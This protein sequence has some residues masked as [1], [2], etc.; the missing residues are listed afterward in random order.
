MTEVGSSGGVDESISGVHETPDK[1]PW[2]DR[3]RF[4]AGMIMVGGLAGAIEGT[5]VANYVRPQ[6]V[7]F[8]QGVDGSTSLTFS[9][10][11]DV[12]IDDLPV[13]GEIHIPHAPID[14]NALSIDGFHT[15]IKLKIDPGQPDAI[16]QVVALGADFD[17]SV[18][19]PLHESIFANLMHGAGIGA[20]VGAGLTWG[21]MK[22][23]R[24]LRND[25]ADTE[26][27]IN[28][29]RQ[30]ADDEDLDSANKQEHKMYRN[31]MVRTVLGTWAAYAAIAGFGGTVDKSLDIESSVKEE[32]ST[33]LSTTVTSAVPELEGATINGAG[34]QINAAI[35]GINNL[36]NNADEFWSQ[37]YDNMVPMINKFYANEGKQFINNPNI[38]TFVHV[39][40]IH[41]NLAN[42]KNYLDKIMPD[43]NPDFILDTGDDQTN[44]GTMFYESRCI[45][46]LEEMARRTGIKLGKQVV[47][48]KVDG[49]HDAIESMQN[50]KDR[51]DLN[52]DHSVVQ[53]LRK[54]VGVGRADPNRTTW[55]TVPG[56]DAEQKDGLAE[57]GH[58]LADDACEQK[59]DGNVVIGVAH[60]PLTLAE[61][62]DKGCVDL[63]V[64][65]HTH[66]EEP[67][68]SF[69][70]RDGRRVLVHVGGTT[71]GADT[72]PPLY[73]AAEKDSTIST[74]YYDET[75]EEFVSQAT[76]TLHPDGSVDMIFANL[77]KAPRNLEQEKNIHDFLDAHPED[78]ASNDNASANNKFAII[79]NR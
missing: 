67:T 18:V 5:A 37:G 53:L 57:T 68:F 74:I 79:D 11:A 4:R 13:K 77:R 1:L 66:D 70:A 29:L 22:Y 10:G 34:E 7:M 60:E 44:S 23:I 40:D 6:E 49:N 2:L 28:R 30:R 32:G 59:A 75:T 16:N 76:F 33:P 41:C 9:E 62:I 52:G 47:L 27:E 19:E 72:Q 69:Y 17:K 51:Y 15:D 8:T 56:T 42:Y 50:G 46:E 58:Q 3:W 48:V 25:R 65:G 31:S 12:N 21:G 64:A 20:A 35:L 55:A 63:G 78:E 26:H 71:S 36:K 43:L 54:V 39:S 73:E 45:P 61:A 24:H 38:K 14:S